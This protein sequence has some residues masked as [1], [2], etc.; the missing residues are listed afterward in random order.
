[1]LILLYKDGESKRVPAIDA[2]GWLAQGW[3]TTPAVPVEENPDPTPDTEQRKT[4]K[5]ES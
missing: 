5:R 3:T 2:P 4:R 1:M